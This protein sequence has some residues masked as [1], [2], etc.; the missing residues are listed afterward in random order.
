MARQVF[1]VRHDALPSGS[2]WRL[3]KAAPKRRNAV[4][5]GPLTHRPAIANGEALHT[6]PA[7]LC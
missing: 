2:R 7:I 4:A 3:T 1:R 5:R 6:Y